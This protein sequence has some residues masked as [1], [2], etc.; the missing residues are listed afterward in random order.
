MGILRKKRNLQLLVRDIVCYDV[1][2]NS[3][4]ASSVVSDNKALPAIKFGNEVIP[5]LLYW[6]EEADAFWRQIP[7]Q[8]R[9]K[10]K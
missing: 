5:E 1:C 6:I 7:C 3:I 4:I 2:A 9:M 8:S 10:H